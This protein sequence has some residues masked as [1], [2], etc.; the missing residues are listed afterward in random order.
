MT[1]LTAALL[2][3]LSM[4]LCASLAGTVV[5]VAHRNETADD[6]ELLKTFLFA[7]VVAMAI[8]W[9]ISRTDAVRMRLNPQLRIEA[10]IQKNALYAAVE[11]FAPSDAKTLWTF[12]GTRMARG[13]TLSQAL[14]ETRTFL[15]Q[16]VNER[17]G[18]ADQK[19]R[20]AWGRVAV[21]TLEELQARDP[22]LCYRFMATQTLDE[23]E[24][25]HALSAE[26]SAAFQTAV[27]QLYQATSAGMQR[28]G[29]A[30]GDVRVEFNEA[31]REFSVIQADIEQQFGKPAADVVGH[32][33]LPLTPVVSP[34]V[35]CSARI[36]QLQAMLKRPQGKAAMMIDSVLR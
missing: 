14:L 1:M 10:E 13:E 18:F 32:K 24:S 2:I 9:S 5:W 3:L 28:R 8:L 35:A 22:V 30:P 21:D 16:A 27:V 29:L 33:E 17:L 4:P 26:N 19:S 23:Q 6:S 36:F 34:D 20:L 25:L 12:L 15:T 7:L 31:A 11:Q